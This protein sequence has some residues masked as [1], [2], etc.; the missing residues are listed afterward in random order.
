MHRQNLLWRGS[1]HFLDVHASAGGE[2]QYRQAVLRVESDAGVEL[3]G[4]LGL[5]AQQHALGFLAFDDQ[6]E[7]SPGM[8]DQLGLVFDDF[9]PAG[10][11][12]AA[13]HH[14]R[15][16]YHRVA[17][18]LDRAQCF[19]HRTNQ[20]RLGNTYA[21]LGENFPAFML[22]KP[23]RF[24]SSLKPRSPAEAAIAPAG[25]RVRPVQLCSWIIRYITATF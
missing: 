24:S 5:L 25:G 11:A 16:D 14:L 21:K 9:H 2:H 8:L 15:L 20:H 12:A 4:D 22:E 1:G 23:H 17:E 18:G 3:A 13:T 10:L 7:N 19:F 6:A